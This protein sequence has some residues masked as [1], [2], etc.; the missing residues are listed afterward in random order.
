MTLFRSA[1][2]LDAAF[3]IIAPSNF[4]FSLSF[5]MPSVKLLYD[6]LL[7]VLRAIAQDTL[8]A[9]VTDLLKSFLRL[10]AAGNGHTSA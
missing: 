1:T 3:P 2:V 8:A 4:P 6:L 9:L 10:S 7:C 5:F